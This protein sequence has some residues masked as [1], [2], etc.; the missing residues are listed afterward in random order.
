MAIPG[1]R[2]Q[3]KTR[4]AACKSSVLEATCAL[5]ESANG[6]LLDSFPGVLKAK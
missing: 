2:C 6:P 5:V 4:K 3:W 1:N